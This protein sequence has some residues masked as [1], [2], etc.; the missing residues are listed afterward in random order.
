MRFKEIDVLFVHIPKTGG[1]TITYSIAKNV[2]KEEFN[3]YVNNGKKSNFIL[4]LYNY[5]ERRVIKRSKRKAHGT[6]LEY[7]N[8]LG[9]EVYNKH[10][11]F[12][13]IRNP[14]EQIRSLFLQLTYMNIKQNPRFKPYKTMTF[15]EF[16]MGSGKYS[17]EGND[18]LLDQKRF[19]T[20]ESGENIIVD[21]LFC[22][23]YYKESVSIVSKKINIHI[24]TDR[25]LRVTEDDGAM[26]NPDMV[27]KVVDNY[28]HVY[29]FYK[30]V[31]KDFEKDVLSKK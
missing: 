15:E 9:E 24:N 17:M 25:K 12:A 19:V 23:D 30:K 26:Y 27:S 6:A 7:R 8:I 2:Y 1:T 13:F 5:N 28:G 18:F 16:I 21:D 10:Y 3:K 22:F 4:G 31:K 29:E 11:S 20:D 14:F